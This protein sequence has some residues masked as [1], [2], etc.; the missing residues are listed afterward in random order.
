MGSVGR[1]GVVIV[2]D[3]SCDMV[4]T[5]NHN[6]EFYANESCGQCTPCREGSLCMKKITDRRLAGVGVTQDPATHKTVAGN[7]AVRPI[8]AFGEACAWPTQRFIEK[9][10]DEFA[11]RAQN[12][13]P[14]PLPPEITPEEL[15]A[16]KE[17]IAVPD[18]RDPGW[19]KVGAAGLV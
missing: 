12:P 17:I 9:F 5:L 13:V 11:E 18:A 19:D 7:I 15:I 1:T 6:N 14:P 2:L 3:D 10:P 8:C 16:E 4:G